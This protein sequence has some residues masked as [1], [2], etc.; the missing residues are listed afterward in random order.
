MTTTTTTT[1]NNNNGDKQK[2]EAVPLNC[3]IC[4]EDIKLQGKIE[5]GH[6]FCFGCIEQWSKKENTCPLCKQRF[7]SIRKVGISTPVDMFID[8]T[9][10]AVSERSQ[11]PFSLQNPSFYR[12]LAGEFPLLSAHVL[13]GTIIS[14]YFESGHV[15]EVTSLAESLRRFE[16]R[17]Q[18]L[19]ATGT[20]L[21]TSS[22]TTSATAVST[23]S[24]ATSAAA[25]K[26]SIHLTS[27]NTQR[28]VI[29]LTCNDDDDDNDNDDSDNNERAK[30]RPRKN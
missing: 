23:V 15:M 17:R 18:E 12:F 8:P 28:T 25:P 4:Y 6:E 20:M 19:L 3:S 7:T 1:V 2:G 29:D 21:R 11:T 22:T 14:Q 30:K 27:E 5:C 9:P 10:M 13:F 26:R 24:S 16:R